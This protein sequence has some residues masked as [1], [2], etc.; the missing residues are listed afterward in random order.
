MTENFGADSR[1][2]IA[3]DRKPSPFSTSP[4]NKSD[5]FIANLQIYSMGQAHG[6]V[7]MNLDRK[8]IVAGHPI[9]KVR[10]FLK[11]HFEYE[12]DVS[13]AQRLSA[14]YFGSD[15]EAVL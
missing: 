14:E 15:S 6:D 9:K 8:E 3:C 13:C 10:D 7:W 4:L 11:H 12:I 1:A 2:S 5:C